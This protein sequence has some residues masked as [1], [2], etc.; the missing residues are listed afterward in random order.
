MG[1]TQ[2]VL[3][4]SGNIQETIRELSGNFRGTF[5]E[6]STNDQP[7]R[8]TFELQAWLSLSKSSP[9]AVSCALWKSSSP[10]SEGNSITQMILEFELNVNCVYVQHRMLNFTK[11]AT[12][13]SRKYPHM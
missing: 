12:F 4:H 6:H 2:S 10:F 11:Q 8:L 7:T 5:N 13:L 9:L 1:S 3:D